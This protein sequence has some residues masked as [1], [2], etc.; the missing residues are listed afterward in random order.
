M[1][2]FATRIRTID[3]L[4]LHTLKDIYYAERQFVTI[5]PEMIKKTGDAVLKILLS[6]HV[7][8]TNQQITRL[9][10]IFHAMGKP[11]AGLPCE[12]IIGIIDEARQVMSEIHDEHVLD[13][14]IASSVRNLEHYEMSRY[15]TLIALAKRL[16]KKEYLHPL[17]ETLNEEKEADRWLIL[18]TE[19]KANE[20]SGSYI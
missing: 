10:K 3:D 15:D 12:T 5:L 9:D 17:Q 11:P 2:L 18:I 19:P 1:G 13:A 16:G 14:A 20:Y 8:E 7:N 6:R 4:F